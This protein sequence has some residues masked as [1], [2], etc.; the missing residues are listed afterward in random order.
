MIE[1][2]PLAAKRLVAFEE[3]RARLK[4][5]RRRLKTALEKATKTTL[6]YG[7]KT[8]GGL[9]A[10]RLNDV[11]QAREALEKASEQFRSEE[12]SLNTIIDL[13]PRPLDRL[14]LKLRYFSEM[15]P[16]QISESAEIS[17]SCY[18]ARLER[19]VKS[20]DGLLGGRE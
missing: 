4:F 17:L 5:E 1:K 12:R 7:E 3:E 19:A 9:P 16:S 11:A 18:Y 15:T 13:I 20:L 14:V 2:Y 10:D 8:S 6:R